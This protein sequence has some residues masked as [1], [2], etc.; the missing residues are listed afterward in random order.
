MRVGRKRGYN[1]MKG[2]VEI[3]GAIIRAYKR[4][5]HKNRNVETD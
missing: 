5:P 1:G 4:N 3:A 2:I